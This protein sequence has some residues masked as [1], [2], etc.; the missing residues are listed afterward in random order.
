MII[1]IHAHVFPGLTDQGRQALVNEFLADGVDLVLASSV[2]DLERY[3][4][5]EAVRRDNEDCAAFARATGG[6]SRWLAYLNPQNDNW[7]EELDRCVRDGAVG[8]KLWVALKEKDRG[9]DRTRELIAHAAERNLAVLIHT[10]NHTDPCP[11][12]EIDIGEFASLAEAVP[13]ARLVAAHAGGNWR[14]SIG[15]LAGMPNACVD[16]CGSFPARGMVE[17][18]VEDLGADRVLFGSDMPGRSLSSQL[19]K[20]ML[21]DLSVEQKELVL[22]KNAARV[23]GLDIPEPPRPASEPAPRR[24]SS[25]LPDPTEDHF[26]FCGRLPFYESGCETP[27][28]LDAVLAESGVR[29]A[30]AADLGSLFRQDLEHANPAFVNACKGLERI[31][32]L[33]VVNP[34]ARNWRMV[35]DNLPAGT[36]GVF[37]SPYLQ[38]WRLDGP[39]HAPFFAECARRRLPLWVNC[40]FGDH[41]FRHSGMAWRPVKAEEVAGLVE[42]AP[43]NAYVLQGLSW[44]A[45]RPAA[46][47]L[48]RRQDFRVEISRLSDFHGQ[49]DAARSAGLLPHLV[50]GSEFPLRHPGEVWWAACRQ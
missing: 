25:E 43:Q 49:L 36:A 9:L 37:V 30:Y 44:G 20:V 23:F 2:G 41:R 22:W 39:A 47:Q 8:I 16:V 11:F 21:A 24:P 38:N 42:T 6:F 29:K 40:A 48:R 10:F 3:P 45:I 4:A 15:V 12:G 34:R 17:A 26:C 50:V 5:P 31:A 13:D 35:L 33:A 46:E 14:E 19:A 28:A 32:P 1:D 18:L 7:R 27:E